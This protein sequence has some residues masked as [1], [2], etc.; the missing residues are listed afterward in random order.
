MSLRGFHLFFIAVSG[1]LS[2]FMIVWG[3]YDFKA[4]G[5]LMGI[6][7]AL[8]GAAGAVLL[9]VYFRWF[10]KKYPKL[11][12]MLVSLLAA[13]LVLAQGPWAQACGV[14]YKDPNNPLTKGAIMGVIVLGGIISGLLAGIAYIGYSWHRRAKLIHRPL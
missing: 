7:L 14:C 5:D 12:P 11:T 13:G 10:L 3:I 4:T 8:L 2:V 6:G 1:L 9:T